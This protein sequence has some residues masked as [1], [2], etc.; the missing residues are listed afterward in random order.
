[1]VN[2]MI[3]FK[4][5]LSFLIMSN[6]VSCQ[7]KMN[8]TIYDKGF[9]IKDTLLYYNG[10]KISINEPIDHLVK[11]MGKPDRTI[12]DSEKVHLDKSWKWKNRYEAFENYE[13]KI[14]VSAAKQNNEYVDKQFNSIGDAVKEL[15]QFDEY[16]NEKDEF[17]VRQFYVWDDLG[18]S[19]WVEKTRVV[20]VNITLLPPAIFRGSLFEDDDPEFKASF[21]KKLYSGEFTYN[22]KTVNLK[23]LK[24]LEWENFIERLEITDSKFDPPGDSKGWSREIRA[25]DDLYAIFNRYKTTNETSPKIDVISSINIFSYGKKN[26]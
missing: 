6:L 11:V 20:Q 26:N 8:N 15:G 23:N 9:V 1:M 5:F 22:N 19:I 24:I 10:N 13:H 7:E 25:S 3:F 17:N 4:L 18:I 16:Q 14:I 21:P 2:R 12:T